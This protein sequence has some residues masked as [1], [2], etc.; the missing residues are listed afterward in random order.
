M[1]KISLFA[2]LA[3]IIL[4][5]AYKNGFSGRTQSEDTAAVLRTVNMEPPQLKPLPVVTKEEYEAGNVMPGDHTQ[6]MLGVSYCES[7]PDRIYMGQDVSN[8]WVSRDFGQNWFNLQNKGLGSHFV[9]SVETDPLDKNRV[10]AAV[11][12]RIYDMANAGE[13]GIYLSKDGGINW[14]KSE[15]RKKLGEIRGSTRLIAYAPTSKDVAK[16]YA[17]R[18]Y[19]AFSQYRN[20]KEGLASDDGLLYSDNG[21]ESWTEVRKLPETLFGSQIRG[22]KVHTTKKDEVFIYGNKGLFRFEDATNPRGAYTKLSGRGGLP[23]GD[24][25]GELYQS[26]NG[27]VLIVAVAGNGIYKSTDGGT[28][29]SSL[30]QWPYINYCYINKKFPDKIFAVPSEKSG[31]QIH[32]SS[33]GGQSWE[34]PQSVTYRPGYTGGWSTLLNGQF[35]YILPDPRNVNRVFIHTKS[36]NFRSV[37][38]GKNWTVSDNG[39]NGA[40]HI[41]AE[42]MFDPTNPDRFAYFMTDRGAVVTTNR[43][44]WFSGADLKPKQYGLTWKSAIAGALRPGC[45]TILACIN[46]GTVGKL[47]LSPDNGQSWHLVSDGNKPRMVVAYDLQDPNFC[48]QWRER[49]FDGGK[50]WEP[51]TNMPANTIICGVS[52]SNGKVLYAMDI[53]GSRKKIWR[54]TDRGNSWGNPVITASW[55]LTTPGPDKHLFTFNIDPVNENVVYTSS[56]NGQVTRWDLSKAAPVS[57]QIT[58][59]GSGEH[60]F[61]INFFAIDP[62]HPEVM[63]AINQ[64]ANT[65][66]K[67][68]RSSDGGQHWQNISR[69]IPQGSIKGIAVSP[70]TGEVY[71]S[72]ENG[73]IVILPPYPASNTAYAWI[74]YT[75]NVLYE[76]YN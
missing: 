1:K 25:W 26:D 65:G 35:T 4:I 37:D 21:G 63:Y 41:A 75:M 12:C 60:H 50:T 18:W 70:I 44:R 56:A 67:F 59:P 69:F 45:D 68:F 7:D 14:K 46:T 61:F 6:H 11:Q 5:L 54:S 38:G 51:L 42:Q 17:T 30:Y 33:N 40:S 9:M 49:S 29:W 73:S 36:K 28:R 31:Q 8:V 76:P 24:I 22:I 71:T 43:G 55:E 39:Y 19:A 47:F 58:F 20:K 13:Q 27:L 2:V 48:Y 16:G 62:R 23:E 53:D 34:T 74:P 32:I 64:R 52:R 72:G 10:L 66:N 15:S 3:T 57:E